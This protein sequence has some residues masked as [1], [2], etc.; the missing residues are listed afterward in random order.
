MLPC[1]LPPYTNGDSSS[2]KK[3]PFLVGYR[4][5]KWGNYQS[6]GGKINAQKIGKMWHTIF[7]N[8]LK[9]SARKF[10]ALQKIRYS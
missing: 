4:F 6:F 10:T 2:K 3:P 5:L 7:N 9:N 8:Y 1:P